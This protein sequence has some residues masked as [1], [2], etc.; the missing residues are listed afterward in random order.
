MATG[1]Y[2]PRHVDQAL[3]RALESSPIV[4]LDGPRAVGKTT[5]G[6][7]V[8]S[9]S[10]LL[11]RDL[12]TL[13][14]DP[15]AF[16]RAL[17]PP[18]LI[19]EWQLVGTDLLWTIKGIV[20]ADP[21]PGR[22]LLVGSVEP[23]AYGPTYPLTGRAARLVMR[24]MTKAELAGRGGEPTF[25]ERVLA[26]DHPPLGR[27]SEAGFELEALARPGFPGARDLPDAQLFL[28]AYATIVAQRAGDEGRDASR[29]LRSLR[30]LATLTGQ[31]VPDQRI[32]E[33]ADITKVTWKNYD[34]LLSRVHLSAGVAAYESN[35]LKR[36]T[37][38][39]KRFL[40]DTAMALVLSNLRIEDLR[41][42]PTLAGRFLESYV[43]Q[44]LRPQADLVHRGLMHVRTGAG[45][46]EVDA[47]LETP[48]GVLAFEVKLGTRPSAA[49]AK[50]LDWLR[51]GLGGRFGH[52][53]VVYTGRDCYSLSERVTALPVGLL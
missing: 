41:A 30:V 33:A 32:W 21:M 5:T 23:A 11:P 44:Q 22:F 16:L 50:Q 1:Q 47:L 35:R 43:V 53:Y 12:P 28:D 40:A 20:D 52:G 37:S 36:L 34:D 18:V 45:E 2:L 4:I 7:R 48:S 31:T 25:V 46:H 14:V 8:A 39:P 6:S 13:M 3:A 15:E 19:D 29:L 9:T 51:D 24:P 10:V 49:E 42:D 38:Y 26:Q 17:P 27:S